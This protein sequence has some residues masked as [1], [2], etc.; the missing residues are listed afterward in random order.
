MGRKRER[1]RIPRR[2]CAVSSE[3][4]ISNMTGVKVKSWMLNQVSYPGAPNLNSILNAESPGG[5]WVTQLIEHPTSAQV[6]ISQ[7][8]SLSP[9]SGSLLSE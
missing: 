8:M 3:P 4:N 9:P 7:F 2:L 5:I 1:E 6:M